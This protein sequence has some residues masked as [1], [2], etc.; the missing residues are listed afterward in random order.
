MKKIVALFLLCSLTLVSFV[1]CFGIF[2]NG[3][4]PGD[5][6][7]DNPDDNPGD[8]PGD[9]PGGGDVQPTPPD[10]TE[11][12][13][14]D[15][16][17]AVSDWGITTD[18][19]A[20]LAN[21]LA[22]Y[23]HT[24][25]LEN[26][27]TIFFPAGTYEIDLPFALVMKENIRIVGDN[28]VFV[29][30]RA[31][32]TVTSQLPCDDPMIYDSIRDFTATSSMIWIQDCENI[33]VEGITFRYQS[34]TSISG[35]VELVGDFALIKITDGTPIT[36]KEKVMAVTTFDE[37]GV[38]DGKWDAY[39]DFYVQDESERQ[40]VPTLMLDHPDRLDRHLEVGQR[41]CLRTSLESNYVFTAFNSSDLVFQD[42]TINNSFNGG[43]LIEHRAMNATFRRVNVKSENPDALM[44]LNA[45][46]LHIAG[47]G[48]ELIIEDCSFERAGDDTLNVLGPA[49]TIE[50]VNGNT[51][52]YT[53]SWGGDTRWAAVGDTIEFF[54]AEYVQSVGTA[55]V[56]AK[57]ENRITL[58]QLPEGF[59]ADLLLSNKTLHPSVKVKNTVVRNN[60]A[61]GFLI[62]TD[63]VLIESCEFYDTR[64]AAILVS[65][66]VR[67]WKE[68]APTRGITI[69]NNTF[70]NCGSKTWGT[71]VFNT[72]HGTSSM[73]T[74]TYLI[75][76]D[77]S[78]TGNT[79]KASKPA[80]YALNCENITF[81]GNNTSN[82]R[83]VYAA[84]FYGCKNVTHDLSSSAK[85]QSPI[86]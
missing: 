11:T 8:N 3:E 61:R 10:V 65:P 59:H 40:G 9:T 51:I 23:N 17:N 38:P 56:I 76:K 12:L 67:E 71:I 19:G 68:L 46:V 58:D 39:A 34:P 32:N 45:D 72:S 70:E 57:D 66:D 84:E 35:V 82:V 29:N 83:T 44:S 25:M 69:R 7:D 53:L 14:E 27:A 26:G 64:L 62:Q 48:G 52:T 30:T 21:G 42:I 55:R 15:A 79:F 54:E 31:V 5:T 74:N 63:D 2:G 85:V 24:S 22:L 28:A 43:F 4:K 37:N 49:A 50:Y 75:H 18:A 77:I 47:L 86:E 36:G 41:V 33:T 60:R 80:L 13:P 73:Y 81:T 20:G 78:V 16:I 1:S 6:P